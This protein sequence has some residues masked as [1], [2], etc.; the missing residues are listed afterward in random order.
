MFLLYFAFS[1]LMSNPHKIDPSCDDCLEDK[2]EDCIVSTIIPSHMHAHMTVLTGELGP[3]GIG[4]GFCAFMC[5]LTSQFVH[6]R[7]SFSAFVYYLVVVR[8]SLDT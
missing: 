3:F 6:H 7:V 5:F 8:L 4:L 2:R 1:T